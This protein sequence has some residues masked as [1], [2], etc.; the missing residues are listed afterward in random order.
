MPPKANAMIRITHDQRIKYHELKEEFR[1]A[2]G[3]DQVS[4][5]DFMDVLLQLL[6][7]MKSDK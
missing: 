5:T 7:N 1:T 4:D 3:R 6:E 2:T